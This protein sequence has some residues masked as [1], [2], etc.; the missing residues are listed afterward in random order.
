MHSLLDQ[1]WANELD[2]VEF[3]LGALE[4]I[5]L[6]TVRCARRLC[7]KLTHAHFLDGDDE[8]GNPDEAADLLAK[9]HRFLNGLPVAP[10]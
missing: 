8:F 1:Y 2:A 6:D 10:E 5:D 7:Q 3:H 9:F 4:F